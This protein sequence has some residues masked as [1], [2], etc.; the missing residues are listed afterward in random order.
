MKKVTLKNGET[1][2]TDRVTIDGKKLS[3]TFG[4]KREVEDAKAELRAK[5]RRRQRGIPEAQG[6]IKYSDLCNRV[7]DQYAK[8]EGSRKTLSYALA[9]SRQRFDGARVHELE[10]ETIG[11]WLAGLERRDGKP[12]AARSRASAL[13]AMRQVLNRA[14]AWRYIDNNPAR[15][16][17]MPESDADNN[18]PFESWDEVFAVADAIGSFYSPL[19]RF[20]C[21]TGLR[22]QEWQALQWQDV[23]VDARTVRVR[24]TVRS[25]IVAEGKAKT[26][27][28]L[29]AVQLQRFG[30][31]ALADLPTPLTQTQLVLPSP[32]GRLINLHNWRGRTWRRALKAAGLDYRS[33]YAMRDTYATL[34]LAA[35]VPVEAIARQM[36][37]VDKNGNPNPATTLRYYA[38]FLPSVDERNLALLDDY[39]SKSVSRGQKTDGLALESSQA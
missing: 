38:R 36:G 21:A 10:P 9:Y 31:D 6:S 26:R 32:Q 14:V 5:A 19:V 16:V 13:K 29:R 2:W 34:S 30:L 33:P 15:D 22:P 27:G 39:A 17:E 37:H 28:S 18:H 23:E 24:R 35:H 7:L 11:A 1:R 8:S 12:L 4:T 25:G 20:A 3:L